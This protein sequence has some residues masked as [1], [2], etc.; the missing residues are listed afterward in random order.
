M[1]TDM[2]Y[3]S[4]KHTIAMYPICVEY[5]EEEEV[6]KGAIVFLS[7]D[8]KHDNQQVN[9]NHIG[10]CSARKNST[11]TQQSLRFP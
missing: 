3:S 2:A 9:Y 8:K 5:L 4:N 11:P 10:T 6:R 7:D 1:T